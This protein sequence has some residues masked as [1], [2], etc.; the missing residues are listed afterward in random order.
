MYRVHIL[1]LNV[2]HLLVLRHLLESSVPQTL[3]MTRLLA[4]VDV[5]L[6]M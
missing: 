6:D 4:T 5:L 3:H 2:K 1:D